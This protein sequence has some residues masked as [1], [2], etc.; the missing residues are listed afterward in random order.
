MSAA[1]IASEAIREALAIAVAAGNILK[2]VSTKWKPKQVVFMDQ[3]IIPETR[4]Q[5]LSAL[6]GLE[7]VVTAPTPHNAATEDFIDRANDV[8]LAFPAQGE[9]RRWY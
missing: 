6:P 8:V 5:I 3:P 2:L 4:S 9:Q 1:E 7:H